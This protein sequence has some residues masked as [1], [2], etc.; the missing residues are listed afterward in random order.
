METTID[1]NEWSDKQSSFPQQHSVHRFHWRQKEGSK[2]KIKDQEDTSR[3]CR[4]GIFSGLRTAKLSLA[5]VP[6]LVQTRKPAGKSHTP[7]GDPTRF[8]FLFFPHKALESRKRLKQTSGNLFPERR[9][10]M[11]LVISSWFP[12]TNTKLAF[13]DLGSL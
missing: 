4:D 1:G 6:F 7:S 13:S 10:S 12:N 2:H 9:R 11:I 8:L 3:P 5:W